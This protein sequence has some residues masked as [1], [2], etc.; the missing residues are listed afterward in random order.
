MRSPRLLSSML[1]R[2]PS[3][4]FSGGR[5]NRAIAYDTATINRKATG[6]NVRYAAGDPTD[7]LSHQKNADAVEQKTDSDKPL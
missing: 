1:G 2:V 4:H 3:N 5:D 7:S 6:E